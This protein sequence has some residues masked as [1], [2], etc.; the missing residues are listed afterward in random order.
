M[1]HSYQWIL[2]EQKNMFTDNRWRTQTKWNS[3]SISLIISNKWMNKRRESIF[4]D[5]I[6]IFV[7]LSRTNVFYHFSFFSAFL[8]NI[9]PSLASA[10][11][12]L[13][14]AN[15]LSYSTYNKTIFFILWRT[16]L[17]TLFLT[18]FAEWLTSPANFDLKRT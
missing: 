3:R 10:S 11:T 9:F 6:T 5:W 1:L 8:Y 7:K 14:G 15:I 16:V 12:P 17:I 4:L 2:F 18:G 13:S